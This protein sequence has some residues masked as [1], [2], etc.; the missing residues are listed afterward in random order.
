MSDDALT[1][2]ASAA[3]DSVLS[4][5]LSRLSN[6]DGDAAVEDE[7]GVENNAEEEEDP[8]LDAEEE[9]EEEVDNIALLAEESE[10][11]DDPVRMYLREIGKVY[12]L[13][14]DDEKHLARQMEE[15]LHIQA[16]EE[17]YVAAY[18]HP[19]SAAR[20]A[21]SLL[22]QWNGYLPVYKAAKGF[23]DDYEKL[24]AGLAPVLDE[25]GVEIPRRAPKW[26]NPDGPKLK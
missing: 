8:A 26:R 10:G 21:V 22:E 14:A 2:T 23:I 7:D 1:E 19:P 3:D 13:T 18:G 25:N 11:I 16:I 9:E 6:F 17:A 5:V 12:L 4:G 15:G 20:V 24:T